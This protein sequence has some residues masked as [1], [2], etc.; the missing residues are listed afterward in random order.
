MLG[1]P[2]VYESGNEAFRTARGIDIIE[3]AFKPLVQETKAIIDMAIRKRLIDG[4]EKLTLAD[5]KSL[6]NRINSIEVDQ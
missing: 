3:K 4:N 5:L 1:I 6:A 2:C